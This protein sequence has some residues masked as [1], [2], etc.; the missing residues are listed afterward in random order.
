M[1]KA[2]PSI[3]GVRLISVSISCAIAAALLTSCNDS[4]GGG[5]FLSNA[6]AYASELLVTPRRSVY[7]TNNVFQVRE[8]LSVGVMSDGTLYNIPIDQVEIF[9]GSDVDNSSN[10]EPIVTGSKLFSSDWAGSYRVTARFRNLESYYKIW[11][12]STGGGGSVPTTPGTNNPSSGGPGV[13]I[14]WK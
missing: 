5:V 1:Y 14:I 11:V 10:I 6:Q 4:L 13:V 2:I 7:A 9:I 3:K 8:D 12:G